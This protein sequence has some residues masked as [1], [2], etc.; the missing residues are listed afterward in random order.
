MK[1]R[2]LKFII[3]LN[4]VGVIVCLFLSNYIV[5]DGFEHIKISYLVSEGYVPYR[6]FFEHHHPLLWYMF[7]P[8]MYILPH[9][10]ALA[11]YVSRIFSL[12]FSCIML[13]IIG[14]IIN[15]FLG[16][17]DII[18]Y[19]LIILFMF[20]PMWFC[21]SHL[22]PDIIA[23][24]FYFL[25]LY[26]FFCYAE[27]FQTKDMVYCA[28]SFTFAFLTLQN[29]IIS[30][31]P[32]VV[33]VVYLWTKQKKIIKDIAVSS[34]I[35][36]TIIASIVV[37]YVVYD[38]WEPYFQLNWILNAHLFE[39]MHIYEGS[40]FMRWKY[41]VLIGLG[42][43]LWQIKKHQASFYTN[44]IGLLCIA[45]IVQH[46]YFKAVFH[47]YLIILFIFL[48]MLAAP[49]AASI[50]NKIASIVMLIATLV[51]FGLNFNYVWHYDTQIFPKVKALNP[52]EDEYIFNECFRYVNVY[53]KKI[54]YYQL[55]SM[56]AQI[57]NILFNRYPDYDVNEFIE[58]NK[59]KYLDYINIPKKYRDPSDFNEFAR[60]KISDETL[61]KY[62]EIEPALWRRKEEY[63]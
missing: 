18:L 63:Q 49:V 42:T 8:I 34:I 53:S 17:K 3:S 47:H 31:F 44:T 39:Y 51:I 45:E 7:A 43:W 40:V 24:V 21:I 36:L 1:D 25:G 48:A 62:E 50:K 13:C 52:K 59:V 19:F 61:S 38:I 32:L 26:Y 5:F 20:F 57:D 58:T 2:I 22:K 37:V 60:F 23:R 4:I 55:F 15:R 9:N 30:I 41:P 54:S 16:G 28:I 33:P 12:I 10:F 35:P 56:M 14:K 6:D 29:I 27:K 11:Y 46:L